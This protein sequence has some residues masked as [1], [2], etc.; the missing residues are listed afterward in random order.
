MKGIL[1]GLFTILS[2]AYGE[3][4]WYT[5]TLYE[6]WRQ[7][8]SI[9][10]KLYEE[11]TE[12]QHLIIFKNRA[13]GRVLALDGVIQTTEGD[14]FI[15]HEMMTHVPLLAHGNA[16]H[17]LVIGGGDGGILREVLRYPAVEKVTLVEIDDSVVAFSKKYLPTLS[18]G[19]FDDPR[20]AVVIQDGC[21]FVKTTTERFDVIICDSTDPFGPGAVLF[22]PEFY[23][24]CH[25]KLKE[26]GIFVNQSGVPFMQKE[27]LVKIY[28]NLKVHF[29]D[30]GFYL[31]VIPTYAG[32][33]MAFGFSSD[34]VENREVTKEKLVGRLQE[35]SGELSYYTPDIHKAAF[36]L[37]KF[38]ENMLGE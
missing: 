26:G 30:V 17:I 7:T 14:E 37:P 21:E 12:H 33:F 36:V 3:D 25:S 34:N 24:D 9:E 8:F 32:G 22:T 20:V 2:A 19:A 18:N 29:K 1:F 23:G 13:F 35:I 4:A 11:K 16:K 38:I 15:Y 31:G 27:E 28:K 6:N 10:E 5:E